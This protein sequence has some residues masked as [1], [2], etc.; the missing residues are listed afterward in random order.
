MPGHGIF[1]GVTVLIPETLSREGTAREISDLFDFFSDRPVIRA[2]RCMHFS[3][4][5]RVSGVS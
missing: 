1:N 4:A 5:V 3:A 2:M